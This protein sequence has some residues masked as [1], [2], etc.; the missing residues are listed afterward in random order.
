[1]VQHSRRTDFRHQPNIDGAA[2]TN[3]AGTIIAFARYLFDGIAFVGH[4]HASAVALRRHARH[5]AHVTCRGHGQGRRDAAEENPQRHNQRGNPP[6]KETTEHEVNHT[7][8]N[9]ADQGSL[10]E[11]KNS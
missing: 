1:M 3:G 9:P 7:F 10:V 8:W 5:G 4:R 2:G 6:S 11:M